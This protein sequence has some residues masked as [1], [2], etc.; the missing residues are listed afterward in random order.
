MP[1]TVKKLLER[2]AKLIADARELVNEHGDD[3]GNLASDHQQSYDRMMADAAKLQKNAKNL[4]TL[5]DNEAGLNAPNDDELPPDHPME[6]PGRGGNQLTPENRLAVRSYG[7]NANGTGQYSNIITGTRGST[8]YRQAFSNYLAKGEK[9]LSAERFAALQSDSAEAA[10]YMVVSEQF[11]A[12][13]LKE[14]DNLLSVRRYARVHT[15]READSLGIRKRTSRANS[16]SYSTE[17]ALP[18]VDTSLKYGKKVLRP[19]PMVGEIKISRDLARRSMM[20]MDQ[21]AMEEMAG[22]AAEVEETN[23]LF[24]DGQNKPLGVFVDSTDGIDSSRD[25]V[26][27]SNT[28]FTADGLL[29]AKY[30]LKGRYRNSSLGAIR[31][32]FHREAIRDIAKLKDT[33][34]QYLLRVGLGRQQDAA[35]PEDSVLGIP[36]DESELAPNTMTAGNYGGILANWRYYEI[37]DAL[38]LEIQRLDELYARSHEIGFI[39]RLKN[40]G[41][42]TMAEAFVRLKFGM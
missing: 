2:R 30:H 37:A 35:M 29:N 8:A 28:T 36:V 7:R 20:P 32:M 21:V 40:D 16:F 31:W 4:Q 42:P 22:D 5:E 34:G 27:G 24:G 33:E 1:A 19:H 6:Q 17:L 15:V 38:D 10:G 14:L 12:G 41:L 23:F 18:T 13:L 26:T 39:G 25:V 9:G 11:A 3:D